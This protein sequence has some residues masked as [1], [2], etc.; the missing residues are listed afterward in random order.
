MTIPEQATRTTVADVWQAVLDGTVSREDAHAWAAR[1]VEADDVEV[2]DR[3]VWT[4]LQRVH[5]FDL[6]W[7][8]VA[9]T[10]VRHGGSQAYVHSLG[11]LRQALVTWQDDCRSYDAD[12]AGHLRRKMQAARAAAQ[13]DH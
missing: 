10:T 2:P 4:A 3:M 8:D 9:R 5:G 13:R 1:W 7:T 6:V 11:D 12:P